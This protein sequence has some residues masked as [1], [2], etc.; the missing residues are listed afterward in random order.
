[1]A[2]VDEDFVE[3]DKVIVKPATVAPSAEIKELAPDEHKIYIQISSS[4]IQ[5]SL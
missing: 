2:G 1:M 4:L 3:K 5:T